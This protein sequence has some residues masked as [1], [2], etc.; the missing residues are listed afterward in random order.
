MGLEVRWQGCQLWAG[1]SSAQCQC[2]YLLGRCLCAEGEEEEPRATGHERV[3]KVC[4]LKPRCSSHTFHPQLFLPRFFPP[5]QSRS[6]PV[7][8]SQI[9]VA[10]QCLLSNTESSIRVTSPLSTQI[11]DST[12]TPPLRTRDHHP[13][14]CWPLVRFWATSPGAVPP[15]A[16][17]ACDDAW[18]PSQTLL[19]TARCVSRR[20]TRA[21]CEAEPSFRTPAFVYMCVSPSC[22]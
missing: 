10:G 5:P 3:S 18:P 8:L 17:W 11:V 19:L 7:P 4:Y 6:I 13:P 14:Q 1:C 20:C 21:R 22:R 15:S 2:Q 16:P 9:Q 12:R